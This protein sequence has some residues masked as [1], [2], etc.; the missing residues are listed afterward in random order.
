MALRL[1]SVHLY[2]EDLGAILYKFPGIAPEP[3]PY[4]TSRHTGEAGRSEFRAG[5]RDFA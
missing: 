4:L 1:K 2:T 5:G 3:E